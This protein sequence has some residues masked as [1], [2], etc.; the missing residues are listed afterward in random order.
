MNNTSLRFLGEKLEK[1]KDYWLRKLSGDLTVSGV[2]LVVF[3]PAHYNA[4]KQAVNIHLTPH[5]ESKL[6]KIC[7]GNEALI[8][9]DTV[10]ALKICLHK[11]T[12]AEDIIVGT[13]IHQRYAEMASLN[14]VLVLRDRVSEDMTLNQLL[15][16]VK[17][18]LSE[19]YSHQKYPFE[20][21]LNLLQ[22]EHPQNRAPLFNTVIL[23]DNTT[24]RESVSRLKNDVTLAFSITPDSINGTIE[25]NTALFK[26][27]SIKLFSE[28]FKHILRPIVDSP[29]ILISQL[30][31]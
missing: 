14:Q 2:P 17:A 20:N 12:G 22:S 11:Y 1:E 5:I 6:L 15:L 9:T 7:S 4:E 26:K 31:L 24:S 16:D 30:E 28:H 8:F 3:W 21:L 25:Y 27:E 10:T 23:L 19:A 13:T 18:T 29:E